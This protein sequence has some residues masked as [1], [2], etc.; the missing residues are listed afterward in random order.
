[1]HSVEYLFK[2]AKSGLVP[3]VEEAYELAA[4]GGDMV[5]RWNVINTVKTDR[6][7]RVS[8]MRARISPVFASKS[9]RYKVACP[10]DHALVL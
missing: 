5:V 3:G 1:M 9:S 4:L 8:T 10:A 7:T 2:F 6:S